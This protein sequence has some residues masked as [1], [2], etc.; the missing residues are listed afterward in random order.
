MTDY[1]LGQSPTD[2]SDLASNGNTQVDNYTQTLNNG[3]I[4]KNDLLMAESYNIGTFEPET[5]AAIPGNMSITAMTGAGK[6]K[7]IIDLLSR[8]HHQFDAVYLF[9]RTAKAQEIYD[10]IPRES[11]FDRYN[12]EFLVKLWNHHYTKKVTDKKTKLDKVLII[13]DDIINDI[14]YKKSRIIDDY[15][16]GGRHYNFS[17]WFLTQNFTSLKL[18]QR[19]NVRWA[20]A[21]DI[22]AKKE[23]EKFVQ[24]Y[25]SAKNDR[26]GNLLFTKIVKERP[27]QAVV[28]EVY[29][30]GASTEEKVKKYVANPDVKS[31]RLKKN[32]PMVPTQAVG[33][34]NLFLRTK[35]YEDEPV[36]NPG[37]IPRKSRTKRII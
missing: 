31:F 23:R 16:T 4:Y 32:P 3:S 2:G 22:D 20:V 21:F 13:M 10:F 9:S 24:S 28:V 19:N 36:T 6:T 34:E 27:Y 30:N 12:E 29:K 5:I 1:V 25:L 17:V 14:E 26:V 7:F 33:L 15:F 37:T 35:R 11:I 18:L 8:V